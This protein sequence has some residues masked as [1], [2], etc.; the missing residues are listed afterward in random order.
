MTDCRAIDDESIA[1][2]VRLLRAGRLAILPT[3]T[4]YGIAA[5]VRRNG[6]VAAIPAAKGRGADM[7]LQL[8][9]D[10]DLE[11]VSEYAA[12]TNPVSALVEALG[13]GGWTIIAPAVAGWTSPALA[14][15]RTVG[16]RI[17]AVPVIHRIVELLGAPL[18][19]S[20]ANRHGNPSP[21]T[22]SDAIAQLGDASA[23]ALDGG[24]CALASDSTVVDCSS[25]QPVI[26]REG[27]IDRE[28]IARILGLSEIPVVRSVRQ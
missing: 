27:A 17:P 20:S 1:D 25:E 14:G 7:P 8:L 12:L 9:F 18:A 28:T 23:I 24:P 16:F 21:T 11:R 19:A 26:L 6:A 2:T 5:D 4:V 10:N 3:D 15:G 13:P 22:C